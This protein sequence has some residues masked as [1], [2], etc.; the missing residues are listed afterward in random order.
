MRATPEG[1]AET[2]VQINIEIKTINNSIL[3]LFAA[4]NKA[5]KV[6]MELLEAFLDTTEQSACNMI[7]AVKE[8]RAL[9]SEIKREP[10]L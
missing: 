4:A 10:G 1:F 6:N 8:A 9:L 2:T 7:D 5:G 3:E